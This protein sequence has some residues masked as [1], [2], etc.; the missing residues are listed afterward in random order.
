MRSDSRLYKSFWNTSQ[1]SPH[2]LLFPSALSRPYPSIHPHCVHRE[3]STSVFNVSHFPAGTG[4]ASALLPNRGDTQ[5]CIWFHWRCQS[6][7][8][9]HTRSPTT[10]DDVRAAVYSQFSELRWVRAQHMPLTSP[11]PTGTETT[12]AAE[13][14]FA[15]LSLYI[16]LLSPADEMKLNK[17]GTGI[18]ISST[19]I[20]RERYATWTF[21]PN[22][23]YFH[24][25][26]MIDLY[27][28]L[29]RGIK[30]C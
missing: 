23:K 16:T 5:S 7:V 11:K 6:P 28:L 12:A 25:K 26:L 24:Q 30:V 15:Y 2:R 1:I 8:Y 21:D 19:S 3:M 20:W 22:E 29:S 4:P 9:R 27:I 18:E 10:K 14:S 17:A 13:R